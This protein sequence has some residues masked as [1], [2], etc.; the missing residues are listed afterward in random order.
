[1]FEKDWSPIE[2]SRRISVLSLFIDK[3][4]LCDTPG[5]GT[6]GTVAESAE[7][8]NKKRIKTIETIYMYILYIYIYIYIY[9]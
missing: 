9:I 5:V 1:M 4:Q 8:Q 7:K 3:S 6:C 2:N